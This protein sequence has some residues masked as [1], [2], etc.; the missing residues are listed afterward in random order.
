ML[1]AFRATGYVQ[2]QLDTRAA[3]KMQ[4][5]LLPQP[6]RD[7]VVSR[8]SPERASP[9]SSRTRRRFVTHAASPREVGGGVSMPARQLAVIC[10]R[11]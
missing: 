4:R 1:E 10:L 3:I 9:R 7:A 8:Y 5:Q 11:R 6:L 2:P